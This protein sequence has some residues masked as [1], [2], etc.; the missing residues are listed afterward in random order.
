MSAQHTWRP[1]CLVT[2]TALV[3]MV[4]AEGRPTRLTWPHDT[5]NWS[6]N[7]EEFPTRVLPMLSDS[8]A[9]FGQW[10]AQPTTEGRAA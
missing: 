2:V 3:E 6:E 1:G 5:A 9:G 10:L 8:D 7:R 4:A